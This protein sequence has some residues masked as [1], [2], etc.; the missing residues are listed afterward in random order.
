MQNDTVNPN[1]LWEMVKL[2][3]REKSLKYGSSK[4]KKQTQKEEEI[5]QAISTLEKL[6]TEFNGNETQREEVWF[7]LETK[8]HDLETIT[9]LISLGP[10]VHL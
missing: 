9:Q 5:E 8:K 2:K 7:D 4:K 3:V 10:E 1:L 6:V